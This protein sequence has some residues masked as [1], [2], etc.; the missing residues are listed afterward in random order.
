MQLFLRSFFIAF[1]VFSCTHI[2]QAQ[3]SKTCPSI[4]LDRCNEAVTFTWSANPESA[5][6]PD[7][8]RVGRGSGSEVGNTC[9]GTRT[10]A[11][12]VVAG[13]YGFNGRGISP[14][15]VYSA[16]SCSISYAAGIDCSNSCRDGIDNDSREGTDAADVSCNV[17]SCPRGSAT[18]GGPI[19]ANPLNNE[20][21]I[22][23]V[24]GGPATTK[25]TCASGAPTVNCG[26]CIE[27]GAN[28][29]CGAQTTY[30]TNAACE[31]ATQCGPDTT[32]GG[33]TTKFLCPSWATTGAACTTCV[34]GGTNPTC[35]S[36]T[37]YTSQAS[38]QASPSNQCGSSTPPP[39]AGFKCSSN[40]CQACGGTTGVTCDGTGS[41]CSFVSQNCSQPTCGDGVVTSPEEC[42]NGSQNGTSGNTCSATCINVTPMTCGDGIVT[43]PEQCES[44][45]QCPTGSSCSSCSC[46]VD[47]PGSVVQNIGFGSPTG[48]GYNSPVDI[49]VGE[50]VTLNWSATG[51]PDPLTCRIQKLNSSVGY[52]TLNPLLSGRTGSNTRNTWPVGQHIFRQQCDG[53]GGPFNSN[54]A[55]LYVNETSAG[56]VCQSNICQSCTLGT[57][58]CSSSGECSAQGASCGTI[59]PVQK[60]HCVSGACS[61]CGGSRYAACIG[62]EYNNQTSC[63]QSCSVPQTDEA[64]CVG[65]PSI[66]PTRILPNS[67][68][69]VSFKFQNTGTTNWANPTYTVK[70]TSNTYESW[71]NVFG[72][73]TLNPGYI[74]GAPTYGETNTYSQTFTAPSTSGTYPLAF[75]MF[76]NTGTVFGSSCLVNGNGSVTVVNPECNDRIDNN[77]SEDILVDN[78]DPGCLDVNG[79]HNPLDDNERDDASEVML[80]ISAN[81]QLV[82][83]GGSST[84]KY[85]V[86]GCFDAQKG[87]YADWQLVQEGNAIPAASGT[88][89]SGGEQQ[90]PVRNIQSKTTFTLSCGRTTRSATI[91]VLKI[92]EI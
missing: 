11:V 68:F 3:S 9:G 43:A 17:S 57:S 56:F 39:D 69:S 55:I 30:T 26:T 8:C 32:P 47:P 18:V 78:E 65:T 25:Y 23:A 67:N 92:N 52:Q 71:K 85:E 91:S 81:P 87:S 31:A 49:N 35:G 4:V 15:T 12:P 42:D 7:F 86:S 50:N 79:D 5:L 34:E 89:N 58:G 70:A 66:S 59:P 45:S 33:G 61:A 28:P 74:A 77:D 76:K 80:R 83:Q 63:D 36:A 88:R 37:T 40:Q 44:N 20:S 41:G 60:Y 13:T 1:I 54:T 84:V 53:T 19:V 24:S 62:T 46:I 51:G 14:A 21:F 29:T 75:S 6:N 48:L 90:I 2:T 82:R 22:C 73:K 10:L 27:G 64:V 72:S 16:T 38:C